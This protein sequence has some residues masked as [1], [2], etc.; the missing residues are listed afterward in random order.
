[1]VMDIV[2]FVMA[3][4]VERVREVCECGQMRNGNIAEKI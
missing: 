1:M 3:A 2:V 4:A